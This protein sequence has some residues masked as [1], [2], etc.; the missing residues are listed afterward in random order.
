MVAN[1]LSNLVEEGMGWKEREPKGRILRFIN[2][3]EVGEA[4]IETPKD[5]KKD[6]LHEES[7]QKL[8]C[9]INGRRD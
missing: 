5:T 4:V 8:K 9:Q 2:L 3:G 7:N 1:A 6:V